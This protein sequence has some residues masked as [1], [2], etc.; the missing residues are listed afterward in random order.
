MGHEAISTPNIDRLA[1]ESLTFT[2]GYVPSSLCRPSLM[3]II[4]GRYPHQHKVSGNDPPRGTDRTEMLKHIRGA[5]T[6]P[7]LLGDAGYVSLQTGKWW[8]GNYALGGFTQG[9]THGDPA[10]GGRH[11]DDGLAIG[12]QGLAPIYDFLESRG[13]KPFFIWYAP[14]LPHSPHNPPDRLLAKYRGKT[15]S[16]HVARYWAMCEWFDETCGEL[17]DYLDREGLA[18]NTL[19]VYIADNGWIQDPESPRYAERSKRSPYEGGVRTPIMFRWPGHIAPRRDDDTPVSS[20][21]LAPSILAA[22][23]IDP[24]KGMSGF[25]LLESRGLAPRR[26]EGVYG[27]IFEHDVADIDNPAA[28]LLFRWC[29]AD[30]WKLIVP[31]GDRA[32][33]GPVELFDLAADPH[34]TKNLAEREPETVQ[35][36][37][38]RL[39]D[40]WL[41]EK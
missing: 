16:L 12:R 19:V 41:P 35:R 38:A 8:E 6:L 27:E 14:F 21:D 11:G 25:S 29:V 28:S 5:V 2:R 30:R 40:W 32:K 22:C 34:E 9:M 13:D 37:S 17:L 18:E 39:D 33:D 1:K 10:R 36:L 23:G 7:K 20:I 4:T 24:P 3:S 31:H 15:D 26:D